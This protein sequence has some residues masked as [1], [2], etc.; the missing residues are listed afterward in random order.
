MKTINSL[1]EC[2]SVHV[3]DDVHVHN[4]SIQ[5][6][7]KL[8]NTYIQYNAYTIVYSSLPLSPKT[9]VICVH[10]LPLQII[11]INSVHVNF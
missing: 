9:N 6:E 4:T 11:Q 10:V 7:H 8:H 3:H 2:T 5:H 1:P